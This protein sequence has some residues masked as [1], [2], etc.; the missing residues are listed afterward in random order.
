M[1]K[2]TRGEALRDHQ[3][4]HQAH[5]NGQLVMYRPPS[6][7]KRC[8][9]REFTGCTEAHTAA[10][11]SKLRELD[12]EARQRALDTCGLCLFFLRHAAGTECYGP[13]PECEEEHSAGV[14]EVLV[15]TSASVSLVTEED[16]KDED[17]AYVSVAW[18]EAGEGEDDG[19]QDLDDA[20]LE[21][22]A[23]EGDG[24]GV[25]T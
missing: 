19:W 22:E 2:A 20:W 11:C 15:G 24:N 12:P 9:F 14:H 7:G 1:G 16:D 6:E 18:A 4:D 13:I 5:G 25:S 3:E 8:K 10:S 23:E 17:D 21:M